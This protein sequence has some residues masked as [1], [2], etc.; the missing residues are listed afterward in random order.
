MIEGGRRIEKFVARGR[1]CTRRERA[2]KR[3]REL[4]EKLRER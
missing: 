2:R 4:G 3:T 1:R